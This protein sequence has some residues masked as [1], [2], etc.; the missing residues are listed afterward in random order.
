MVKDSEQFKLISNSDGSVSLL[1]LANRKF[2][3][4]EDGGN[5]A[6]IANRDSNSQWEMFNI[7]PNP[8]IYLNHLNYLF[9]SINL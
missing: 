4:A 5:K 1:A 2:V 7:I 9:I 6:L 8:G 3:A